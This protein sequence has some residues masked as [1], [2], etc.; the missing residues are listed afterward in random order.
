MIGLKKEMKKLSSSS[1]DIVGIV[2]PL[3]IVNISHI[4]NKTYNTTKRKIDTGDFTVEEA[5]KIFRAIGFK[6]KSQIEAFEYL[7]TEQG[8]I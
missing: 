8:D 7:F 2:N 6:S 5:F 4:I 3:T 1:V